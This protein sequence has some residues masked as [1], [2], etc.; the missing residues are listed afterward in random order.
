MQTVLILIVAVVSVVIAF[1]LKK[2][3]DQQTQI[4]RRLDVLEVISREGVS[5]ERNDAGHPE[6]GLPIGSPFPD[7]ELPTM[8]GRMM[9][10]EHLLSRG[11]PML[12]FFVSPTCEPCKAL[13]PEIEKWRGELAGKAEV[14]LISSGSAGENKDKFPASF[15][16]D[17]LLQKKREVS[18]SVRAKWTPTAI[19]VRADGTVASYPAAGD[20]AIRELVHE[21]RSA[22][23]SDGQLYFARS[24]NGTKPPKIGEAVPEFVLSD[25]DG[26]EVSDTHLRGSKTLAV[27]WSLT[28]PHCKSMIEDLKKWDETRNSGEPKLVVFSDGSIDDHRELGLRSPIVIDKE[29]KT[30]EKLGMS[31]TPSAVLI[32]EEGRIATETGIGAQNIWALIGKRNLTT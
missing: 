3:F 19:F 28:C 12:L 21:V 26:G 10:F 7:F 17:I 15:G 24:G 9:T 8:N 29:Y 1:Y 11:R 4:L 18:E 25:V 31:G 16:S 5:V 6:D 2:V 13:M 32:D 30:S 23:L 14:I 27:F 20:T 22:D